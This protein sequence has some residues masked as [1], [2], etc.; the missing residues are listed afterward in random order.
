MISFDDS[1][2]GADVML[3]R[4]ELGEA[5][6]EL[7]FDTIDTNGDGKTTRSE[8]SA[9]NAKTTSPAKAPSPGKAGN[10]S[11]GS[12]AGSFSTGVNFF[13]GGAAAA[14]ENS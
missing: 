3:L 5:N 4:D 13:P 6:S 11:S 14:K 2:E 8:L 9:Y 12:S 7:D 10:D 1:G